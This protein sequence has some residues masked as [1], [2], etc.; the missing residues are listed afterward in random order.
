[1]ACA[2]P[3]IA[4]NIGGPAE[5]IQ[6]QK[7]GLL[8]PPAQPKI[9]ATKT[10]ELLNNPTE[11]KKRGTNARKNAIQKYSWEKISEKYHSLYQT[12]N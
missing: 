4:S 10:L 6:H 5:I 8:V 11:L 9:L 12:L 7:T 2:K 3:V 1:M